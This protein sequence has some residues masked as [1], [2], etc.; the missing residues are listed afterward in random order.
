MIF[1]NKNDG[2]TINIYSSAYSTNYRVPTLMHDHLYRMGVA[3]ENVAYNQPP[4]LGYYLPDFIQSFQGVD[5]TGI[6]E[7]ESKHGA[8]DSE[9]YYNLLGVK[10]NNPQKGVYIH[11]GKKILIK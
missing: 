9:D 1:W 4:H 10:V 5:P 8:A 2:A 7:V 11:K 6:V 3:W